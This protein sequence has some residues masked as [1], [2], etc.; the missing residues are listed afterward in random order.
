MSKYAIFGIFLQCI[1]YSL[2]LAGAG[3]AQKVSVEDIRVS[4]EFNQL[5]IEKAFEKIEEL[6]NFEF[7]YKRK[8]ID[9]GKRLTLRQSNISLGELLRNI[10]RQA[11]LRFKRVD[12]TIYVGRKEWSEKALTEELSENLVW[13][14]EISGKV[15]DEQGVGLPG[16]NVLAKGTTIGTVT[17]VNGN[18][19]FNVSDETTVLVFSYVGYLAEEVE[20]SGRSVVN[21]SLSP[22]IETLSEIIVI[23]YG[24]Q[25]KADLTGSVS[26]ISTADLESRPVTNLSA[27]LSGLAPGVQVTQ[28]SGGRIGEDQATIR[29]R[30][31][32]T[33]NNS[34]PLVLVD[35]VSSSMNDIDPNDIANIT[36]LKDAAS[37]AIYGSRAANGVILIT[38]KRGEEGKLTVNY[39]GYV[40]WQ[41]ATKKQEF[42]SD[43][44]TWME[45]ANENRTNGGGAP[46]FTQAEIDEWRNSNDPLTHPNVD[47]YDLQIGGNAFVQSHSL[48]ASGGS[49]K[50]TY[51]FSLGYLNQDGLQKP[52]G[53]KRYSVRANLES[54]IAKGFKLGTNLFYRWTDL[55]PSVN[56]SNGD[57]V[58]FNIVPAIPDIKSPDGRWGGSQHSALGI[59]F[60]PYFNLEL[61]DQNNRQQR[62][63]GSIFADWE[64]IEGLKFKTNLSLN[65]N[66][67]LN[68]RF[69]KTGAAWNFRE[70]D[71]DRE[72][73]LNSA[74]NEHRQ[75][76]LITNFY[77]LEYERNFGNHN[78]KA[79]GGYQ[80]EIYREDKF[81]ASVS[82]F[83]GNSLQVLDAGLSNPGVSGSA[84]EWAIMSFFGRLNYAFKDRYLLEANVRTDGS[85]RF[86]E[87]KKWGVFPSV[88]VGWRI[89]EEDFLKDVSFLS[90]LKIRGS[91]GELGNQLIGNY[92]YQTTYSLNQ[93][94]SFGGT[95]V[96]G[97][98]QNSLANQDITWETTTT[99]NIGLDAGFFDNRLEFTFEY[100]NRKTD[101]ILYELPIPKFLGD[102]DEPTVNLAEVVNKGWETSVNYRSEIS[103]DFRLNTGVHITK[104][105][106]EV[107]KF[108]GDTHAGGTFIIQEGQPFR[109]IRGYEAIG[110]FQSQDEIDD[111]NTPT[112]PGAVGPGDIRYKDQL[113]EDTNGDGIP[114]AGDG[115]INSNDRVVIGNTIPKYL[116]G[117][118]LNVKYKNFDLGIILQGVLDVDTYAGGNFAFQAFNQNDRGLLSKQW[119]NRWTPENPTNWP[120]LVESSAYDGNRDVSSF[121]VNDISYVRLKNVQLGYTVPHSILSKYGIEKMRVYASS[122]NLLT[123]T[124]WIW[125]YDPERTQEA[126]LP[127]LPN[128]TTFIFGLNVQ[129]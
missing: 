72:K 11:S 22:D 129:F 103:N 35:G 125:D 58:D 68:R 53:Q 89:S 109:A 40:G 100:F 101:G 66:T 117:A 99:T 54:E 62:F 75:T 8:V 60:N 77:T 18:Y 94:Y 114:D 56:L 17:D 87:G 104:V 41:K 10:S 115:E 32:G 46:L 61:L 88:S 59:V 111:P 102:K 45:L 4:I 86:R 39:N 97:I 23:G 36:V 44:A 47:W 9:P 116:V 14:K 71:I 81:R 21:I 65:S 26:N 64:I 24:S 27:A 33:L 69:Q 80:Y 37:A 106:N 84:S 19:R 55:N 76:Y 3:K 70:G 83:P 38:T 79:L 78:L 67:A 105:D 121:W 91:W 124:N 96:S 112:H 128:L 127:G 34:N 73:V 20:I 98:A 108:F 50:T 7:A 42:V 13:D 110:I 29:I 92:P 2:I 16:V 51:R 85:S 5:S 120:R 90:D 1:F 63:L 113:T 6:T 95:V 49:E 43:F 126:R 74:S 57:G 12:E 82:E 31:I 119:L 48:S 15:T 123:F 93:N 122:D 30:G 28:G 25:K 52:N 107:T 118:N